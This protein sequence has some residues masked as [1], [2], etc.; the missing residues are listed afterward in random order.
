[1]AL[2]TGL[3]QRYNKALSEFNPRA[4]L[5][6]WDRVRNPWTYLD[7]VDIETIC[8][9]LLMDAS[10]R[11]IAQA[12]VIPQRVMLAWVNNEGS[13]QNAYEEAFQQAADNQMYDAKDLLEN[14]PLYNEAIS[15]AGKRAEH[16]R[17]MAKGMGG[18]RWG[19]KVDVN[20]NLT[21]TVSYQFNIALDDKQKARVIEGE[22]RRI[23]A[24]QQGPTGLDLNELVGAGGRIDL[25]V[26]KEKMT[27][28]E[29]QACEENSDEKDSWIGKTD[30]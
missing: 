18:R 3:K 29:A 11:E 27:Y 12:L 25:S 7:Q 23:E 28:E 15:L 6:Y 13:R 30:G 14:T 16:L 22:A 9:F 10:P 21:A 20:Q 5:G 2:A 24:T 26:G 4:Y 19:N 1:V 8:E 17:H